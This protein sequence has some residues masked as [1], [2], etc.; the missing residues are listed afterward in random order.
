[1]AQSTILRVLTWTCHILALCSESCKVWTSQNQCPS[2]LMHFRC[3]WNTWV[4][5]NFSS[6]ISFYGKLG[7]L[8]CFNIKNPIYY[9]REFINIKIKWHINTFYANQYYFEL[10]PQIPGN[11][12]NLLLHLNSKFLMQILDDKVCSRYENL[13]LYWF[14]F[15]VKNWLWYDSMSLLYVFYFLDQ[16][17]NV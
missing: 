8:Y 10:Q 16:Y 5:A 4:H 14:Y 2:E 7:K 17:Y 3:P 15:W 6:S 12:F 1:M 9:L 13:V 11:Q